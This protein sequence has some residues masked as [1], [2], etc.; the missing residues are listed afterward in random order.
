MIDNANRAVSRVPAGIAEA[1]TRMR[2][3]VHSF[4]SALALVLLCPTLSP[5]LALA[6]RP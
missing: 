1:R 4:I 6:C 3:R 2:T 5:A